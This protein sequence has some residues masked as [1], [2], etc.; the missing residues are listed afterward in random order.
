MAGSDALF[1]S[2]LPDRNFIRQ[3]SSPR[4]GAATIGNQDYPSSYSYRFT[5]CSNCTYDVEVNI[6]SGYT[7][8]TGTFGLTD[9]TRHDATID[10][11]VYFAIYSSTGSVLRPP[12][13]VEWP[14]SVSFD[15]SVTGTSRVKLTVSSGT[16]AEYPCW[17]DARFVR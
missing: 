1:L 4:R 8:F 2:N 12:E 3:P 9:D 10:G 16:N 6:P 15:V 11:L 7:R 14:A 5:N 13:K 17:C